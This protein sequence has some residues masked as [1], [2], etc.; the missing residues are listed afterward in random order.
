MLKNSTE[1]YG[2]VAKFFHWTV[3]LLILSTLILGSL[4]KGKF[5]V[6]IHQ[7]IGLTI[8]TLATLRLLWKLIN[9]SPRLPD[10]ISLFNKIAART[11][12]GLMYV[13]MFGMP[14]TGWSMSMAYGLIPHI[15]SFTF[16]MPGI[17]I[18]QTLGDNL[19]LIH[20]TMAIVLTCL[21]GLHIMG[22]LKHHFIDKD[23]R[24]L[25]SMLPNFLKNQP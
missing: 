1:N 11:V 18:D 25:N 12:Q 14:L 21:V 6:N 2:S 3:A 20:N 19:K 5:L 8:F 13:C 17:P 4:M 7:I 22:A 24:I 10:T 15:G 16:S 9:K 23:H